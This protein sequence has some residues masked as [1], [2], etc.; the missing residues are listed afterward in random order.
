MLSLCAL[1]LLSIHGISQRT[2]VTTTRYD[3][4]ESYIGKDICD[5]HIS[6]MKSYIRQYV[7]GGHDVEN[8][9]D[10]KKALDSYSG[11]RGCR[12]SVVKIDT[13]AQDIHSHN[14]TGVQMFSNFTFSEEGIRMWKAY[15]IGEGKFVHYEKLMKKRSSQGNTSLVVVEPFTLPRVSVGF[16]NKRSKT[17]SNDSENEPCEFSSRSSSRLYQ[18][19]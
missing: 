3:F 8:A 19:I 2:G 4:S 13:S 6:P 7:N 14:W 15:N 12:A 1:L 9:T 16:L 17:R 11:V 18:D 5:R 10:M